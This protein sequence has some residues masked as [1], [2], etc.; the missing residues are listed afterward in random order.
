M[1]P[2]HLPPR[3]SGAAGSGVPALE[4]FT[5]MTAKPSASLLLKG[6]LGEQRRAVPT[7][8]AVHAA[9]AAAGRRLLLPHLQGS[10]EAKHW[11]RHLGPGRGHAS[12]TEASGRQVN[13]LQRGAPVD[14]SSC[15]TALPCSLRPQ[16]PRF[17]WQE[18]APDQS[19][20]GQGGWMTPSPCEEPAPEP[21]RPEAGGGG[22]RPGLSAPALASVCHRPRDTAGAWASLQQ[23]TLLPACSPTPARREPAGHWLVLCG[24]GLR[25]MEWTRHLGDLS[26]ILSTSCRL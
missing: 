9:S 23:G 14:G 15:L 21:T 17:H 1:G 12:T 26:R 6:R 20:G 22:T 2:Q 18:E 25:G 7:P 19:L 11:P 10:L 24:P 8:V 4:R 16:L 5:P 13:P 3:R